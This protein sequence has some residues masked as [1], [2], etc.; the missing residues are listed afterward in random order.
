MRKNCLSSH[1]QGITNVVDAK[2]R[3]GLS[4]EKKI[5]LAVGKSGTGAS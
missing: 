5:K 4:G 2:E 3:V 1:T